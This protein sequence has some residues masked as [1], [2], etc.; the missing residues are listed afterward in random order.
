MS[1]VLPFFALKLFLHQIQKLINIKYHL[2]NQTY[3]ETLLCV[4]I[5]LFSILATIYFIGVYSIQIAL[6]I[7]IIYEVFLLFIN[8][9]IKLKNTDYLNYAKILKSAFILVLICFLIYLLLDN[10]F[11]IKNTIFMLLKIIVYLVLTYFLGYL[12]RKHTLI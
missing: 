8:C 10:I 11:Y 9:F 4:C 7:M 6:A 2:E 1:F 12:F 3:I 5:V